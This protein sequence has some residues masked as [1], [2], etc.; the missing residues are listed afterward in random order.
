VEV[1]EMKRKPEVVGV[2]VDMDEA[3]AIAKIVKGMI[4]SLEEAE[5]LGLTVR[6][7]PEERLHVLLRTKYVIIK[8]S[9]VARN[10]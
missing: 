8:E 2:A 7:F 9:E 3:K 6:D 5:K 1:D 4:I 10:E